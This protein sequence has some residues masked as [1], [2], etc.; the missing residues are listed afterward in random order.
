MIL[1]T[2]HYHGRRLL[3]Y[4][5]IIIIRMDMMSISSSIAA[6]FSRQPCQWQWSY[7][8]KVLRRMAEAMALRFRMAGT[9]SGAI[10]GYCYIAVEYYDD[11]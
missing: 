5:D 1:I 8:Y 11:R 3:H 6:A 4:Y 7:H 9:P 2:I 10:H